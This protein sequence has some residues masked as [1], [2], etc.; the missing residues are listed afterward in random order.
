[1]EIVQ[2]TEIGKFIHVSDLKKLPYHF[3]SEYIDFSIKI[4]KRNCLLFHSKALNAI[5]PVSSYRVR[6]FRLLQPIFPPLSPTGE[7]M[8]LDNERIFLND[9]ITIV[10]KNRTGIRVIQPPGYSVFQATPEHS[11]FCP[12]GTYLLTLE[13]RSESEI[14]EKIHPKHRNVIRNAIKEG[15]EIRWGDDTLDDFYEL[16]QSTMQR[17]SMYCEPADYFR[18]MK[19]FLK[20]MLL[21]G[22]AYYKGKPQGALIV[23]YSGYGGFYMFGATAP[24]VEVTGSMNLLQWEVIKLLLKKGVKRYD[25]AGA[26]LSNVTATKLEGIQN[27]K[28]RFGGE[29]VQGYLWKMD[30]DSTSCKIFDNLLKVNRLLKGGK[31]YNDIIDE[32][33]EKCNPK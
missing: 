30:I 26:R 33:L 8:S 14:F 6:S 10:K 1:M 2:H 7:K 21:C 29:L 12:F 22:V 16:Y 24:K 20:D 27:F 5:M 15:V 17:S 25:F 31:K 19:F 9:F 11:I 23:P 28:K 18:Q 3:S 32:E 4:L 13:N